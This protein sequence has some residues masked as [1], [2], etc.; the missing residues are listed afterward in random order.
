MGMPYCA[1]AAS[2]AAAAAEVEAI[3][4]VEE[5]VQL[6]SPFHVRE[7][8]GKGSGAPAPPSWLCCG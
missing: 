5:K 4:A 7:P 2:A 3:D 6:S 8:A 1:A